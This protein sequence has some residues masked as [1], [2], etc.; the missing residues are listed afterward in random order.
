MFLQ[1]ADVLVIHKH[2]HGAA[3]TTILGAE[4][5]ANPM[6]PTLHLGNRVRD[7]PRP[8]LDRIFT[9]A[10]APEGG[11]NGNSNHGRV[12]LGVDQFRLV[13]DPKRFELTQTRANLPRLSHVTGNRIQG[14]EAVAS[15]A[16]DRA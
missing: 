3:D 9:A 14:F 6:E 10:E 15:D 8:D 1:E 5:F 16:Q 2:Q 4:A 12:R 7:S 11:R 13:R